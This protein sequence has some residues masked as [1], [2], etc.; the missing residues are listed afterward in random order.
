MLQVYC[1]NDIVAF[2]YQTFCFVDRESIGKGLFR[3]QPWWD[4]YITA[5]R[6]AGYRLSIF[7]AFVNC[8]GAHFSYFSLPHVFP[9]FTF[10]CHLSCLCQADKTRNGQNSCRWPTVFFITIAFL[11]WS[12][13]FLS[14]FTN[15]FW[16]F[17]A[18]WCRLFRCIIRDIFELHNIHIIFNAFK[19]ITRVYTAY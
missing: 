18:E 12:G 1:S 16:H 2:Q 4:T 7:Y 6:K 11:L 9:H 5:M 3:W 13:Y 15:R 8:L 17:V 10:P 19:K 14:I